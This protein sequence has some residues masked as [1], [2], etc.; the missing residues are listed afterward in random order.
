MELLCIADLANRRA[1]RLSL[2]NRQR[3]ALARALIGQPRLLVL[4]EPSNGLDPAGIV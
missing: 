2:G 4:D 3:L 1:G